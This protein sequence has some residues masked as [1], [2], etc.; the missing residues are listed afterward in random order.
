MRHRFS[1]FEKRAWA[2]YLFLMLLG[3]SLNLI[4]VLAN[5]GKMPVSTTELLNSN[6]HTNL[7]EHSR[8]PMLADIFRLDVPI[9]GDGIH[10][11]GDLFIYASL[12]LAIIL[13]LGYCVLWLRH[14]YR[15]FFS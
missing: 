1:S 11:I 5:G 12:Y 3:A 9:F 14:L 7:N 13:L 6:R 2:T 8:L 4:V 15:R 10:S